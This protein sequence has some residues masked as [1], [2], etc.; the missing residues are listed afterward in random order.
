MFLNDE[1]VLGIGVVFNVVEVEVE[2]NVFENGIGV[3]KELELFVKFICDIFLEVFELNKG[4][5]WLRGRVVVV[6]LY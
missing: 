4:N 1:M 6:V 2:L 3:G 5:N